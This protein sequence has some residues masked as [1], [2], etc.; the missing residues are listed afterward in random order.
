MLQQFMFQLLSEDQGDD[1]HPE[2]GIVLEL[3]AVGLVLPFGP[4][5]HLNEPQKCV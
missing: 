4:D 3:P 1:G 5:A 2:A